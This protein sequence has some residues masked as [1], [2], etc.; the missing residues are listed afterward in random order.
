MASIV[1]QFARSGQFANARQ[2]AEEV[3]EELAKVAGAQRYHPN[4]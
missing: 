1:K 2:V 4:Y 3:S